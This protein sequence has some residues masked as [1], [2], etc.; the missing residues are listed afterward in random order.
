MTTST[1]S[2]TRAIDYVGAVDR[3]R[4]ERMNAY[5]DTFGPGQGY[6]GEKIETP[7]DAH[8]WNPA[9]AELWS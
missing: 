3:R 9:R 1:D 6:I 8:G 5:T 7:R 4:G 2:L